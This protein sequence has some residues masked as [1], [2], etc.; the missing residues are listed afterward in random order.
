MSTPRR[1]F[2][3]MSFGHQFVVWAVRVWRDE[4]LCH[5]R[6]DL[7]LREGF[8]RLGAPEGLVPF[9]VMMEQVCAAPATAPA[10]SLGEPRWV[11]ADEW[12]LAETVAGQI[13]GAPS[14]LATL[15]LA[16]KARGPALNDLAV[17]LARAGL[18]FAS[19]SR[20]AAP[21]PRSPWPVLRPATAVL[22]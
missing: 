20:H 11:S 13:R 17:A 14:I 1:R 18:R 3:E 8:A 16:T 9:L 10:V 22:H 19:L 21:P 4:D 15:P 2:A 12:T 7:L 5:G 6:R